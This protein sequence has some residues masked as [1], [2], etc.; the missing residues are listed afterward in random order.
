MTGTGMMLATASAADSTNTA[1][2]ASAAT[3][4]VA[5]IGLIGATIRANRK[6]DTV[7]APP[8]TPSALP[9]LAAFNGTQVE[10]LELVVKRHNELDAKYESLTKEF[11]K[12]KARTDRFQGAVSRY[13]QLLAQAWPG[14]GKMPQ[15]DEADI[16][17]LGE[18][19]P[20]ARSRRRQKPQGRPEGSAAL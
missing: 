5:I 9:Q 19:L 12:E 13:L 14:P 1:L 16:D 8:S 7:P 6:P 4:V 17:V 11:E 20:W 10:F 15:P 3:I 2:I 18:T